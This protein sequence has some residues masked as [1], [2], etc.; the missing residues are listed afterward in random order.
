MSIK[1]H[2]IMLK[3]FIYLLTYLLTYLLIVRPCWTSVERRH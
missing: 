3:L 1:I 2:Y